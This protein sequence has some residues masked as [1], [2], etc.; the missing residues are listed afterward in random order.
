MVWDLRQ[1]MR[2]RSE[3]RMYSNVLLTFLFATVAGSI[4]LIVNWNG[5]PHPAVMWICGVSAGFLLL[6]SIAR[7]M[8]P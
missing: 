7:W 3:H 1:H 2:G 6:L 5:S 8:R 4:A